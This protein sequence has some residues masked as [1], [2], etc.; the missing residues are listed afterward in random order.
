MKSIIKNIVAKAVILTAAIFG[1][2]ACTPNKLVV[3]Q[4]ASTIE[5]QRDTGGATS[6]RV[7][8]RDEPNAVHRTSATPTP[9]VVVPPAKPETD[10][11]RRELADLQAQR[12]SVRRELAAAAKD[13]DQAV[14]DRVKAAAGV[15]QEQRA[16][17][18]LAG[19]INRLSTKKAA[20]E[21]ELADLITRRD[22]TRTEIAESQHAADAVAAEV[23]R[24]TQAKTAKE[25]ELAA[26]A[27]DL[28]K[29]KDALASAN[30]A[31][32]AS[33][34]RVTEVNK[35]QMDAEAALAIARAA[36][37]SVKADTAKA[38]ADRDDVRS[39]IEARRRE[40]A[41]LADRR[42]QA[43]ADSTVG[44]A[45][46]MVPAATNPS[47]ATP[48]KTDWPTGAGS[49]ADLPQTN[50]ADG[51]RQASAAPAAGGYPTWRMATLGATAVLG[52]AAI[53]GILIWL[54]PRGSYTCILHSLKADQDVS[55]AVRGGCEGVVLTADGAVT[56][57]PLECLHAGDTYLSVNTFGNPML[58][59]GEGVSVNGETVSAG[60]RIKLR[61]GARI[62]VGPSAAFEFRSCLRSD[63]QEESETALAA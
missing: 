8:P 10:S 26:V 46:K 51:S 35:Q 27:T 13:R 20:L 38:A 41:E 29:A 4:G 61:P 39:Q 28:G 48:T 40:L 16:A 18:E 14:N 5:V 60:S 54:A 43:G 17:V 52:L 37:D 42:S 34:R 3:D 31:V 19:E 7:T 21:K 47:P 56:M 58:W 30:A 62:S 49:T 9:P 59:A 36:L 24:L 2:T 23:K 45:A 6:V 12:D 50:G 44:A 15:E 63:V 11:A 1:V 55:H 25:Q 57:T 53:A 22:K 32:A 33:E